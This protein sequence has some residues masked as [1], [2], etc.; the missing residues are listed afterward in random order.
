MTLG[1]KLAAFWLI[2]FFPY[3][4]LVDHGPWHYLTLHG[5]EFVLNVNVKFL[6]S[7]MWDFTYPSRCKLKR[8]TL[9][10]SYW[11]CCAQS[12]L[13]LCHVMVCSLPSPSVHG[14]FQARILEWVAISYCRGS[15]WPRNRIHVSSVS[16]TG[17]Q[18]LYHWATQEA[19]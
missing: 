2:K 5:Q 19:I 8:N 18:I 10:K 6:V 3:E 12:H 9:P 16:F 13:T 11:L 1:L 14:V 4:L 15:S 17:R 7:S